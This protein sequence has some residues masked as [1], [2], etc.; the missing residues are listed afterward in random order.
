[1]S[2]ILRVDSIQTSS[3]GS[4]TASGLG[5]GGVGKIGQV[6][7][8]TYSTQTETTSTSHSDTGLTATITPTS[9]SSKIYIQAMISCGVYRNNAESYL[10]LDIV[11]GS[12]NI[13]TEGSQ[14][15][16]GY[17]GG[18]SAYQHYNTKTLSY[19]DSPSTTSATT[20]KVTFAQDGGGTA[21]VQHQGTTSTIVLMEVLA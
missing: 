20:Y 16:G 15:F 7:S 18:A 1:M 21:R 10:N 9:T 6:V 11:R 19:L 8:S 14:N 5:I 13:Y 17:I 4:A 12:T 3:G 2:S